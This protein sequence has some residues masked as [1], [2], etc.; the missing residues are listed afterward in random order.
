MKVRFYDIEWD[1]GGRDP[2]E[3][4][5]ELPTEVV[6]EVDDDLDLDEDTNA[7]DVLTDHFD[8]CVIGLEY[9]V[10]QG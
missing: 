7:A 6:L 10:L 9:E 3:P 8:W 5:P 4:E 2:D 1:T